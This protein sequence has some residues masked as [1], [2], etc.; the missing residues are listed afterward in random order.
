MAAEPDVRPEEVAEYAFA[1]AGELAELAR[2][3]G[4]QAL[5][6]RLEE[7][8]LTAQAALAMLHGAPPENAAPGDAA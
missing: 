7:T 5:A 4:L 1:M 2:R 6:G 3:V 8:H